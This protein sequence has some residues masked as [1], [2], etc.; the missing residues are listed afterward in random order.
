MT[1]LN[2]LNYDFFDIFKCAV[3]IFSFTVK[4]VTLIRHRTWNPSLSRCNSGTSLYIVSHGVSIFLAILAVWSVAIVLNYSRFQTWNI[5]IRFSENVLPVWGVRYL[6][7]PK[8]AEFISHLLPIQRT[9]TMKYL[10]KWR[11]CQ[12]LFV[13]LTISLAR[14]SL[15]IS[16]ARS[17]SSQSIIL[18]RIRRIVY[19]FGNIKS[20][21]INDDTLIHCF[22]STLEKGWKIATIHLRTR[23]SIFQSI[24]SAGS[25]VL[26][27]KAP[28]NRKT[29]L[30][31]IIKKVSMQ[32]RMTII[33]V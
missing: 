24:I 26:G 12:S 22:C 21:L 25:K 14:W 1:A 18:R 2:W 28:S 29:L 6:I 3:N 8:D 17:L 15:A 16:F 27:N 32:F 31:V 20:P 23:A 7:K 30:T 33:T 4:F 19:W 5:S 9:V 13:G 10:L 11:T